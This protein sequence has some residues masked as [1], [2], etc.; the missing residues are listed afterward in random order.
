MLRAVDANVAVARKAIYPSFSL[1][2]SA[3]LASDT[4]SLSDP[5]KTLNLGAGITQSIFDFGKRRRQIELSEA[6]QQEML[7]SYYKVVLTALAEVED[8]LSNEQLSRKLEVQ[9]Q[10]LI[11]EN[12]LIVT[13]TER[14]YKAGA[15][16]LTNLLDA[17]ADELQ[18]E[19]QL[20][21]LYQD[22]LNASLN[23]YK[24]LGGGW[25]VNE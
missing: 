2:A 4:L 18:A 1:N 5:T 12:R 19:D 10:Q 3:R 15:E 21:V 22:R 7:L 6:R 13:H 23:V 9:Q 11:K 25:Q 14:L 24:V 17:Q 8:A 20:L 16:K